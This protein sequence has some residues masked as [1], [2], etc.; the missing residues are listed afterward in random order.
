M[1]YILF[2]I[3]LSTF[4]IGLLGQDDNIADSSKIVINPKKATMLSKKDAGVKAFRYLFSN[5]LQNKSSYLKFGER[6]LYSTSFVWLPNQGYYHENWLHEFTWYNSLSLNINKSIYVGIHYLYIFTKGSTIYTESQS[7]QYG[8][9]GLVLQYDFLPRFE[10]RLYFE[11][12]Y[13]KGDYCPCDDDPYKLPDLSYLGIGFGYDFPVFK[14]ITFRMGFTNYLVIDDIK[15]KSNFTQ[16][17][18][19]FNINLGKNSY[20]TDLSFLELFN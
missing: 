7:E 11:T 17:V 5:T 18:L 16:Y 12:S 9:Y 19:G 6:I 4:S 15:D 2:I 10:N 1:K 13:N 8:I 3:L 20:R 14:R